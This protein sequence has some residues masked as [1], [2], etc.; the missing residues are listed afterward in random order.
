MPAALVASIH[1]L[2][3]CRRWNGLPVRLVNIVVATRGMLSNIR[4]SAWVTGISI[5]GPGLPGRR[6]CPG[7]GG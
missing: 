5:S 6:I 7:A 1:N 2:Q 3:K 4:L